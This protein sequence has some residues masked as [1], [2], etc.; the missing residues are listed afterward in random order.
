MKELHRLLI[1]FGIMFGLLGLCLYELY[2]A[3]EVYR[4]DHRPPCTCEMVKNKECVP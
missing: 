1:L 2:V 3:R 4:I